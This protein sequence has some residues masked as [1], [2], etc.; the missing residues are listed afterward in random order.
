[1]F[2]AFATMQANAQ[3]FF[4]L[5]AEQVRTDSIAPS[6]SHTVALPENYVDSVYSVSIA[7]PEFIDMPYAD[8]LNYKKLSGTLPPSMPEV[9]THIVFD[10]KKPYLSTSFCPIVYRSGKYQILVSFLLKQ[11]STPKHSPKSKTAKVKAEAADRYAAHS[12]LANGRW[13]KI[14]VPSSGVYQLTDALIRQAGFSDLKKVKVYGY[15]GNL[16]PEVIDAEYIA[17]HDDLKE[18]PTCNIGGRRVFYANGPVTWDSS[19]ATRRTRNPYSDYG[20][21]FITET[22]D[23]PATVDSAAF[24]SSFYPSANDYHTHY[25]VDGYAWYN[26]GRNLFDSHRV[27]NGSSYAIKLMG[28]ANSKRARLAVNVSAGASSVVQVSVNDSVVGNIRTSI[29]DTKYIFGCQTASTFTINNAAAE[30]EIKF[31]VNAGGPVRLD[32]ATFVWENP[33]PLADM[34]SGLL[35][36]PQYVYTITNQDHHADA[37]ADMVII[38]PTSQKLL[39]QAQRLKAFHEQ[40]DGMK[41]NIVPADELY[42]EFSSGTPDASAYRRYMKMLYDRAETEAE[43]PKFLVLFGD[44]VWDNRMLTSNCS[45]FD[46]NDYLLAYESEESFDKRYCYIDDGFFCYLDDGEGQRPLWVD[47]LDVAVGRFPVTTDAEAKVIV[48][49]TIAYAENKNGGAWQNTLFFMGDDGDNNQHMDDANEVADLVTSTYPS[50]MVKKVMWD[51]YTR[52]T[53]STGNTYPEVTRIIKQQQQA[54]ALIMNYAG[55]GSEIQMSHEKVLRITDFA[56]FTNTNLPLWVTASCDIMPFDSNNSTIGETA[57][58]NDKGG[59]VAFYGTTRTVYASQNTE[60]NKAFTKQVLSYNA[61]G[62]P[63]AIGE[64][65]RLAKNTSSYESLARNSLQYSLLGDPALALHLPTAKAVVDEI[66]GTSTGQGKEILL[67]AGSLTTIKGHIEDGADFNGIVNVTVRDNRELVVC[68]LNDKGEASKAFTYYDRPN[69]L[70]TGSDSIRGGKFEI[71]FPVPKDINYSNETGIIN[72]YAINHDHTM[73]ANGHD[74]SFTVGGSSI[75]DNDSIGPSIYCYL[76]SPSFANGGDVNSTPYFVAQ[77][78]DK[79]GIN[80]TGNGIGHDLQLIIDGKQAYTFSLND[81]F[82][83]DFGSYTSGTTFYNIPELEVGKHKLQFRAWDVLNNVSIAELQFNVVKGLKPSCRIDCTNNPAIDNTTFII[84]HDRSGGEVTV[85][86]D[87]FDMSGRQLW[88]HDETGTSTGNTYT[89]DWNLTID[90][91]QKL[92]T[93]VYLYRVRLTSEGG[94]RTSKAKKLIVIG[95]K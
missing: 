20:Y 24:V 8:V 3:K 37:Q 58:L 13:A 52:E 15:G 44:C 86:I 12:V 28:N 42:N 10:R 21:Y 90:S 9:S 76:N 77:I 66:N 79:D 75:A 2:L 18:V 94:T 39:K 25:E 62:S 91:G 74:E 68:R 45:K 43:M 69:T 81:N 36:T 55:H 73:I 80:A 87:V 61:D 49:K 29:G 23:A 88:R 46:P 14:S 71:T 47:K 27:D 67:K 41:V 11:E 82:T 65:Q 6:F 1:M 31:T 93:G 84:S 89:V 35:P 26:G 54:G 19:A 40:H 51:T 33:L 16:Q 38:I 56:A 50:F 60:L 53:S 59:A 30:N 78:M 57:M 48:D 22:D 95:N 63:I 64:A 34:K 7:Y 70:Y 72:I 32:Y 92:Q 85:G 17:E 83:Y 5:T 4:N